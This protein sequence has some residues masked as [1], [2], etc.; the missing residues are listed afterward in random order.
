MRLTIKNSSINLDPKEFKNTEVSFTFLHGR[1]F[2]V[3][4]KFL[5]LNE[6]IGAVGKEALKPGQDKNELKE[7]SRV[8]T[9]VSE[10]GYQKGD[11]N[12]FVL[13]IAKIKHCFSKVK[14]NKLLATLNQAA[15]SASVPNAPHQTPTTG[16]GKKPSQ[17]FSEI[18]KLIEEEAA[19]DTTFKTMLDKLTSTSLEKILLSD[20]HKDQA[21]WLLSSTASKDVN[22]SLCKQ[23]LDKGA[24]P[25]FKDP[26]GKATSL[27]C[28][29]A[30]E[31]GPL[32]RLLLEAGADPTIPE[33][34][35]LSLLEFAKLQKNQDVI[36]LLEKATLASAYD[37]F[38]NW[39]SKTNFKVDEYEQASA[40]LKAMAQKLPKEEM[41]LHYHE[42]RFGFSFFYGEL[43][44]QEEFVPLHFQVGRILSKQKELEPEGTWLPVILPK[45]NEAV[46]A[47]ITEEKDRDHGSEKTSSYLDN[48][49]RTARSLHKPMQK[50]TSEAYKILKALILYAPSVKNEL[51]NAKY[52]ELRKLIPEYPELLD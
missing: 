12:F 2:K 14:R 25:D 39:S 51:G 29:I 44:N 27:V 1:K 16:T 41:K 31:N 33:P 7:W 11:T 48:L 50:N 15:Q 24:N 52:D 3:G 17:D 28:A 4:D 22:L 5:S 42:F 35:G 13:L 37:E 49:L 6:V 21:L 9:E 20:E 19:V 32:V 26:Q 46:S 10:K 43:S 8:F 18:K 45:N 47:K 34:S 40:K 36:A 30:Q 23:L 38:V